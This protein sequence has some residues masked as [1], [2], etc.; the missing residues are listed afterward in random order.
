MSVDNFTQIVTGI[1]ALAVVLGSFV[2]VGLG[3]PLPDMLTAGFG[4]VL[5][6]FF[7]NQAGIARAR[8]R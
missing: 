2:L 5:G 4:L 6:F 1:I 8:A 7:G 3:I